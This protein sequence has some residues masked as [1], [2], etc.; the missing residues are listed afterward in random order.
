VPFVADK[1]IFGG[2]QE[3]AEAIW[4]ISKNDLY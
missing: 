1:G 4:H 2:H 3:K